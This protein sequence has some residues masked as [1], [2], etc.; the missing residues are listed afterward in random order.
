MKYAYLFTCLIPLQPEATGDD[1]CMCLWVQL[2]IFGK[3]LQ[4]KKEGKEGGSQNEEEMKERKKE[5][6]RG[7][8]KDG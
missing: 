6:G 1:L 8:E 4:E 3:P 5:E 2:L 7:W